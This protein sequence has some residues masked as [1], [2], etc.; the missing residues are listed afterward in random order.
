LYSPASGPCSRG[1]PA[2]RI[3]PSLED[4]HFYRKKIKLTKQPATAFIFFDKYIL[5]YFV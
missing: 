2:C 5:K 1:A 4:A 3:P